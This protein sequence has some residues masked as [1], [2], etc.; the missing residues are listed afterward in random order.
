MLLV[1]VGLGLTC[2]P[3][4]AQP[5]GDVR[6]IPRPQQAA[7]TSTSSH[8]LTE[9]HAIH[10]PAALAAEA[11]YLAEE[12]A[13]RGLNLKV[14]HR[15][16][17]AIGVVLKLC[18]T[19]ASPEAYRL[20]I[21]S[22]RVTIAGSTPAGVFYGIQSLLQLLDNAPQAGATLPV[23]TLPDAPRYAWRGFMLDEA[24]HFFGREKVLQLL[25]LMARYKLNRLHWHLTDGVGWRL[26][27]DAYPRLTEEA[28]WPVGK[29]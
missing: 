24:R 23:G 20:D 7:L 28:A 2:L 29:T 1:L 21:G 10:A 18:D 19:L 25:D 13:A 27:I 4:M 11:D 26:A 9:G 14:R 6:I 12:L 8:A 22:H 17:A 16:R 5:G 3:L 15:G